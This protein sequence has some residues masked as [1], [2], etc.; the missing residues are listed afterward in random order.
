M[1]RGS[2][3]PRWGAALAA[4][5]LSLAAAG[6]A[7]AQPVDQAT[8]ITARKVAADALALFDK[9]RYAEALEKFELANRLVPAPTLG[10][11]AARCLEKLGRLVEASERYLDVTRMKLEPGAPFQHRKA[12]VDAI[13]ERD[14]LEPRIPSLE[15]VVGGPTGKGVTVSL[16]GKPIPP[17]LLGQ[18]QPADPGKH[19]IE[20]AREDTRVK[21][22]VEL[23]EGEPSRVEL[24]LPPLPP[25]PK[26]PPPPSILPVLGWTGVGV[27][28]GLLAVGVANGV[29]AI[30]QQSSLLERC[31]DRNCPPDAHGASDFY[32]VTRAFSTVGFVLGGVAA[33]GGVACLVLAPRPHSD[34]E[35]AAP[36]AAFITWG[37]AGV[38]GFF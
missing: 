4:L 14:K 9:G 31:P 20:A 17:L 8:R 29:A 27:G 38:R 6:E 10:L 22:E 12:Q 37:G 2:R 35:G 13:Q 23:R 30:A 18:K 33:A 11:R 16:D 26:P 24:E 28:A 3:L 1:P 36:A 5:I 19:V 25:P 34:A 21:R 32:D 7:A 15:I